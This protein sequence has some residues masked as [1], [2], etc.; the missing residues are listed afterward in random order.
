MELDVCGEEIMEE[1]KKKRCEG[2]KVRNSSR[3]RAH[4]KKEK[5]NVWCLSRSKTTCFGL[6]RNGKAGVLWYLMVLRPFFNWFHSGVVGTT[7]HVIFTSSFPLSFQSLVL[8]M[9]FTLCNILALVISQKSL[10]ER[11]LLFIEIH[12][13]LLTDVIVFSF[14]ECLFFPFPLLWPFLN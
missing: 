4:F 6:T 11:T 5:R 2:K 9:G 1:M 10:W 12:L 7:C 8:V 3:E 14:S 13:T